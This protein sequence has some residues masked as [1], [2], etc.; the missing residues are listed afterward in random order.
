LPMFREHILQHFRRRYGNLHLPAGAGVLTF[1]IP[2]GTEEECLLFKFTAETK[3]K[4]VQFLKPCGRTTQFSA[5][6]HCQAQNQRWKEL[7]R[8]CLESFFNPPSPPIQ[9][10]TLFEK[11]KTSFSLK[12]THDLI[13]SAYLDWPSP[14]TLGRSSD[15]ASISRLGYLG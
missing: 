13:H 3:L 15:N 6:L 2:S 4:R 7:V 9:E 5:R 12:S 1:G 14:N 8:G 10:T 11:W